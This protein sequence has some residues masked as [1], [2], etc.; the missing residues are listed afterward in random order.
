MLE[1]E[2]MFSAKVQSRGVEDAFKEEDPRAI[3][4]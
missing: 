1:E 4:C 3:D 2:G